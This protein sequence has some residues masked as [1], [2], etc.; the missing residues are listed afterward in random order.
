MLK[1]NIIIIYSYILVRYY[2]WSLPN[3]LMKTDGPDEF[4]L[5]INNSDALEYFSLCKDW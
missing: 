4:G 3:S 2:L 5:A 1:K